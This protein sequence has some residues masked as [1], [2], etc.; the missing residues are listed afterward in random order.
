MTIFYPD[1]SGFQGAI[2]LKGALAVAAKV[3]EGTTFVSPAWDA[4]K[5]E[6]P[7]PTPRVGGRAHAQRAPPPRRMAVPRRAPVQ[8][9][10]GRLHRLPRVCVRREAGPGAGR[11]RPRR[12]PAAGDDGST[13][14]PAATARPL[15]ALR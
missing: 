15:P 4:Q 8:R 11:R 1:I 3:T 10:A 12:V 5:A 13:Q 9:A 14:A 7:H 6:A 2:S